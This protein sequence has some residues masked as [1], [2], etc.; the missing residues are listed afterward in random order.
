M[1]GRVLQKEQKRKKE[2]E[3]KRERESETE[4]NK[5]KDTE[6]KPSLLTGRFLPSS[7]FNLFRFQPI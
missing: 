1:V 7:I 6:R 2:R 5:E 4:S 3:G